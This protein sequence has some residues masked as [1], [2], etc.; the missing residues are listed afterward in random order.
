MRQAPP[1]RGFSLP[2]ETGRR[3]SRSFRCRRKI[4]T[5]CRRLF[6]HRGRLGRRAPKVQCRIVAREQRHAGDRAFPA[7]PEGLRRTVMI[8]MLLALTMLIAARIALA[9]DARSS[10]PYYGTA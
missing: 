4:P 2:S 5:P 8:R 10:M 6:T 9:D 1:A 7:N 3:I